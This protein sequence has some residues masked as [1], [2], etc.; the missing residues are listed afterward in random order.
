MSSWITL[1][2][3]MNAKILLMKSVI[4]LSVLLLSVLEGKYFSVQ[5]KQTLCKRGT[6]MKQPGWFW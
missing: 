2:I 4:G 6:N 3:S 5:L 1:D